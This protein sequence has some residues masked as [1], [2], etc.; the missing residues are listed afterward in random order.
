MYFL[1]TR[2]DV[3]M[4]PKI[5]LLPLRSNVLLVTFILFGILLSKVPSYKYSAIFLRL[6]GSN[7]IVVVIKKDGSIHYLRRIERSYRQ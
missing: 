2:T 5:V 3:I 6:F 4:W 1:K 7:L